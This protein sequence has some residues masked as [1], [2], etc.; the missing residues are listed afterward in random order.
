MKRLL[1][2]LLLFL[3][4]GIAWGGTALPGDSVY[5]FQAG[6]VDQDG[7]DWRWA[8]RR[9]HVQIVSMFYTSCTMVCPMI[10]DTMKLTAQAV[11]AKERPRLD[12]LLVSFDPARDTPGVLHDYA[13]R[14]KLPT[15]PWTFARASRD[16]DT[17]QI[18]ALLGLQYRQLPDGDFNHSSELVLL[19][20]EGRVVARTSEIGRVDPG[21]VAAVNRAL[22][23][24]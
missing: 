1:F 20:A 2:L 13:A 15:P 8:D 24:P 17:R 11:D 22:G 4:T 3:V 10:V 12:L 5:Q 19:D 23:V 6:L 16:T 9:G 14:R 18:A 7:H 21:F